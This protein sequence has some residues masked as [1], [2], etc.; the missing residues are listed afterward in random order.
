MTVDLVASIYAGNRRKA[1]RLIS[2]L[3][4][5]GL[6]IVPDDRHKVLGDLLLDPPSRNERNPVYTFKENRNE[7]E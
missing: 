7:Y 2:L 3:R 4:E 6:V 1:T 5:L